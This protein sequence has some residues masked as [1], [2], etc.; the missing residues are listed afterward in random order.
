VKA[1]KCHPDFSSLPVGQVLSKVRAEA[2]NNEMTFEMPRVWGQ[3]FVEVV[4]R[5]IP[6]I[7]VQVENDG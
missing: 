4:R 5:D 7:A 6:Q 1:L 3:L 2:P